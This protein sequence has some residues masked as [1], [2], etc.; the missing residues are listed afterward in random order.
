MTLELKETHLG[1]LSPF[2]RSPSTSTITD[3]E[4]KGQPN[5]GS[6]NPA[7]DNAI[8]ECGVATCLD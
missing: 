1:P 3:K 2:S 4:G 7:A 8:G 6:P 5:A